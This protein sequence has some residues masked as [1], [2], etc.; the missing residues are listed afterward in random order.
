MNNTKKQTNNDSFPSCLVVG[1]SMYDAAA[2]TLTPQYLNVSMVAA[3]AVPRAS[4]ET[5]LAIR[6]QSSY[7]NVDQH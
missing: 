1:R 7:N 4:M 6:N 2:C 5:D 3:C